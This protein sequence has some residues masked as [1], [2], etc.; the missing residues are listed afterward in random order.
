MTYEQY[1]QSQIKKPPRGAVEGL[2][3]LSI[4][5]IL[6][7]GGQGE[8]RADVS[9]SDK[10]RHTDIALET[11]D[12]KRGEIEQPIYQQYGGEQRQFSPKSKQIFHNSAQHF[13][14]PADLQNLDQTRAGKHNRR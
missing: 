11:A 3:F 13:I 12:E 14:S 5:C 2:F 7:N 10:N 6:M 1:T 9:Y 8:N 4:L